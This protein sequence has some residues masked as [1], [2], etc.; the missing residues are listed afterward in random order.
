[1][2]KENIEKT[3]VELNTLFSQLT[4]NQKRREI[5]NKLNEMIQTIHSLKNNNI[6]LRPV[7]E[8]YHT[9]EEYLC[10]LHSIIY[11]LENDL[12]NLLTNEE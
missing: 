7:H 8:E 3:Y 4:T 12:G 2:M 1:M 9:E 11:R 6:N 5:A 10:Y